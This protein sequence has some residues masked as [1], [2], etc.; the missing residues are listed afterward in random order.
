MQRTL[1]FDP[2]EYDLLAGLEE[3]GFSDSGDK[4]AFA[5]VIANPIFVLVFR[6]DTVGDFIRLIEKNFGTHR[7]GQVKFNIFPI[8]C[9]N[10][11]GPPTALS[12]TVN[13]MRPS[14]D[15]HTVFG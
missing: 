2:V 9:N 6:M 12:L 7:A 1:R 13:V 3:R 15:C 14:S 5:F 8:Q 10:S 4:L 11:C